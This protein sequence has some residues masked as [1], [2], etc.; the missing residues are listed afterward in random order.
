MLYTANMLI[1]LIAVQYIGFLVLEI[2][3]SWTKNLPYDSTILKG[4][5]RACHQ[6]GTLQ[7]LP[8]SRADQGTGQRPAARQIIFPCLCF[9]S[10]NFQGLH[11]GP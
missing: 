2:L 4:V 6:P 5:R 9:G 7:W 1:A 11:G 10:R 3:T 8:G